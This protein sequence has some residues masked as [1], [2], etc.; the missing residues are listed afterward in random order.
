[1][2][3]HKNKKQKPEEKNQ[4]RGDDNFVIHPDIKKSV[5]VV[6]LLALAIVFILAAVERAGPVGKF[7]YRILNRL[8]G[9][10]YYL[11]PF[12]FFVGAFAFVNP[13]RKRALWIPLAAGGLFLISGLGIIDIAFSGK[14]GLVGGAIGAL[15]IPFGVPASFVIMFAALIASFLVMLNRPVKF[16]ARKKK[17]E[18]E[19]EVENVKIHIPESADEKSKKEE[20]RKDRREKLDANI[21]RDRADGEAAKETVEEEKD[22][23]SGKR[24]GLAEQFKK[25]VLPPLTLLIS[26]VDR[27]TIGDL[28]ANANVIKRTLESF[29]IPVEMGG[30]NVGPAVTRYT[31]KPAEG[32]KLSRITSLHQD[33]ALALAAHPIRIEAPIPG[34][35]FVGIEVPNRSAALV[36]LGSLLGYADFGKAECM[37]FALGRNVAGEPVFVNIAKLPHLLIA[38]ATGSGK[39][40]AIH[41]LLISLL[42]KNPPATLRLILVDPK[43]VELSLYHGIPHLLAPV[44]TD[45]KQA[46]NSLRWAITEMERRYELLLE[47]GARDIKGYNKKK[48]RLPYIAIVIDELADLMAS[49]GREV[50]GSIIRLAQ[51]SRATG[52][53]LV[54]STQRPSVEVITGLIKANITS[55]IALQVASQVDSRTILDTAG[56]EKL[57]G[58]GDL[59][60]ISPEH[61]K[62]VRIQGAYVTEEEVKRVVDFIVKNNKI[63]ETEEEIEE[64]KNESG[65]S[66]FSDTV[67]FTKFNEDD[68]E[69]ELYGAAVETVRA[70]KKAS[71][72]LLQ[73]RLKIGY[74]RAAR[75]LD[76]MEERGIIGPGEGAKPREVYLDTTE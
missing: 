12:I 46:I 5:R 17:K 33:L 19:W 24:R 35:S 28:R 18:P 31:L 64:N 2:P 3:R 4:K 56:A 55:R 25:Y 26:S 58:S 10:G 71:A 15:Q 42:Y 68:E 9:W 21:G 70:A 36:R 34:Q 20:S 62:P 67:D 44:I 30:V 23:F 45:S 16:F 14:G 65:E 43:K 47:E 27:P 63:E 52:I 29:G 48:F 76:I 32:V 60:F 41:S 66:P 8:F 73:R 39:S 69:D 72:S 6:L 54:V 57:L 74:A 40:V 49:Y 50:E 61:S 37:T 59:L 1:M 75:L 13:L 38:G 51:M 22:F 11:F 53:H 7:L